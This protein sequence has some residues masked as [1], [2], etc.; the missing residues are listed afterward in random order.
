MTPAALLLARV[1]A[2]DERREALVRWA[3]GARYDD[4]EAMRALASFAGAALSGATTR[5]LEELFRRAVR[6]ELPARDDLLRASAAVV[7]ADILAGVRA[8]RSG[9]GTPWS[10]AHALGLPDD[11]DDWLTIDRWYARAHDDYADDVSDVD[12]AVRR[13]A[14]QLAAR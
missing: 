5:A 8:P 4:D 12:D 7:A 10:I 2:G 14:R 6:E 3:A 13:A 11:L 1:L 9:A